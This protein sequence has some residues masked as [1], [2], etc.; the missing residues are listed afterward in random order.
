MAWLSNLEL[1]V[2][3]PVRPPPPS[4]NL[5]YQVVDRQIGPVPPTI[6]YDYLPPLSL[7]RRPQY[8][9]RW[10]CRIKHIQLLT[11]SLKVS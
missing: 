9:S 10:C 8:R 2:L 11:R 1:P 7:A 5:T 6:L 3:Q 4:S